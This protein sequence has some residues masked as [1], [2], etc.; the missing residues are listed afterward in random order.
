MAPGA[1][2][3]GPAPPDAVT[4]VLTVRNVELMRQG[5]LEALATVEL[6]VSGVLIELQVTVLATRH[7]GLCCSVPT[8]TRPDKGRVP[9]VKLPADLWQAV[10]EQVLAAVA[11][12]V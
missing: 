9:A 3:D 7:A 1:T 6:D 2:A 12:A 11:E 10:S 5:I 8:F 4:V